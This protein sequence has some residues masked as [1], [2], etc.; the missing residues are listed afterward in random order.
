[1]NEENPSPFI[2]IHKRRKWLR[3]ENLKWPEQ[4]IPVPP[5]RWP[6]SEAR[7]RVALF[8]SREFI[9]Q[10]F[11]VCQGLMRVSVNRSEIDDSGNW[12][13]D[14]S[15]DELQQIKNFIGFSD[16]D[17]VEVFPRMEDEVNVAN[18]RHLW[19]L[20][21]PLSFAWRDNNTNTDHEGNQLIERPT[22]RF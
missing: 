2:D 22:H 18:M 17:A 10:V 7:N 11:M 13:A 15:W 21:E 19:I 20:D 5:D 8:R 9:I 16:K 1:M 4:P 3:A 12:V 14:I 6:K